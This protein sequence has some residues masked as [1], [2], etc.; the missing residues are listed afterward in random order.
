MI[1]LNIGC[2][3]RMKEGFVNIDINKNCK[4][5]VLLNITKEKLPYNHSEIDYIFCDNVI[6]HLDEYDIEFVMKEFY[7]VIKKDCEIYIRV[8]YHSSSGSHY[9]RHKQGLAYYS[10]RDFDID[11]GPGIQ[12]RDMPSFKFKTR[13]QFSGGFP[14]LGIVWN[15]LFNLPKICTFYND[16]GWC[17]II[18]A[19]CIIFKL[20]K[21]K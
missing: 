2:G 4:P 20:K 10:I 6:E 7:R 9:F 13:L 19:Q 21:V 8:P 18:P 12:V 16:S 14:Y 17:Y 15:F 11:K 3:Y 5:D 1:K